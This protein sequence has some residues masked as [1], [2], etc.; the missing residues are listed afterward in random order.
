[1]PVGSM[2]LKQPDD[3]GHLVVDV[4]ECSLV[5]VHLIVVPQH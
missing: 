5:L 1:M 4:S 3:H 2:N